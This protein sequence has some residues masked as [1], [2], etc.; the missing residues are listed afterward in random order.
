[1]APSS[2]AVAT[3]PVQI[4]SD[5]TPQVQY[6]HKQPPSWAARSCPKCDHKRSAFTTTGVRGRTRRLASPRREVCTM[7]ERNP[8]DFM[9][10][11]RTARVIAPPARS[12]IPCF[13]DDAFLMRS[14]SPARRAYMVVPPAATTSTSAYTIN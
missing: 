8:D 2:Q 3:A 9:Q 1:M 7:C 12:Q 6:N 11:T 4:V 13:I 14:N 5:P 10:N